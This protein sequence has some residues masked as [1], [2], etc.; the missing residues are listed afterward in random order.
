MAYAL[1]MLRFR[2][3][4]LHGEG[5]PARKRLGRRFW[6]LVTT[7]DVILIGVSLTALGVALLWLSHACSTFLGATL[8]EVGKEVGATVLALGIIAAVW[9]LYARRSFTREVLDSV[10]LA[11]DVADSGLQQIC[12]NYNLDIPW[13]DLFSRSTEVSLFFSYARTWRNSNIQHIEKLA[14][15]NGARLRVILPNP[16]NPVIVDELARRFSQEAKNVYDSIWESANY[17]SKLPSRFPNGAAVEC[18]FVDASPLMAIYLFAESGILSLHSH[19]RER[20]EVPAFQVEVKRPIYEFIKTEF[21]SLYARSQPSDMRI[22][23]L[24]AATTPLPG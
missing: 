9:E 17:Y 16:E 12:W 3:S 6:H 24:P 15:R 8:T 5:M 1:T 22:A 14:A 21:E 18:R 7:R 11:S 2:L 20:T 19:R 23:T 4:R 13:G 10:G